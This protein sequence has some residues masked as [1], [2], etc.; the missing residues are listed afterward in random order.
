MTHKRILFFKVP[1]IDEFSW[2]FL[3]YG[4]I[5]LHWSQSVY[6]VL[7]N[8]AR[9]GSL[10]IGLLFVCGAAC[11]RGKRTI[12]ECFPVLALS[13]VYFALIQFLTLIQEHAC[14]RNTQQLIFIATT[15]VM[16]WTGYVIARGKKRI[17]ITAN[18]LSFAICAG[19]AVLFLLGFLSFVQSI[20]FHGSERGYGLTTLN[21]VGVAYANTVLMLV[22]M[23]LGFLCKN[24]W[25]KF[26]L[27]IA[28]AFALLVV[29]SSA[30][31]GAIIW[32]MAAIVFWVFL[33]RIHKLLSLKSLIILAVTVIVILPT[34]IYF[35]HTNYAIG[36]RIDILL[37][38]FESMFYELI[39]DSSD[40]DLAISSR[41]ETWNYY[42]A[43]FTGWILLGEKYYSGYYPHNQ[44]LEILVRYGILGVPLLLLSLYLFVRLGWD[45][46]VRRSHPDIEFTLISV[47][48][49]YSYLQSMSSLS[50]DVNRTL[51]FGFG[52]LLGY[53][54]EKGIR[55]SANFDEMVRPEPSSW[56]NVRR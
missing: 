5:C 19:C 41:R 43:N 34:V 56:M 1:T 3:V 18:H 6:F 28:S 20:S 53:F 42:F 37:E 21:P 44:W 33:C 45:T 10:A 13:A 48:F 24:I 7:G 4:L 8:T 11:I 27:L 14:W 17:W 16:F 47:I 12:A 26:V 39:G 38:R 50:L 54:Y 52:Y 2:L 36:E 22:F 29:L 9:M 31:R 35:Y 23:I 30:S 32:G 46:F 25:Y 49:V 15:M 40:S 51:W 55:G